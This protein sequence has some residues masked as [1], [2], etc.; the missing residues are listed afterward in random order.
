MTRGESHRTILYAQ[1]G[2]IYAI[3]ALLT[4]IALIPIYIMLVNATRSTEEINLGLSLIPGGNIMHNWEALTRGWGAGLLARGFFNSAFIAISTT[5]LNV[6]FSA[7]TAYG[8]HIYRFKGR[9]V[10]WAAILIIIMLPASLSFI[11]FFQFMANVNLLNNYVPLI[12][13]AIAGA[14]SVLFIRQYM[15]SFTAGAL[16]EAARI[17]G[18]NEFFIFN[19]VVLPL[20]TPA[21]AAQ[22][23]FTFV[24]SW[25]NLLIPFVLISSRDRY[26]LPMLVQMLRGDIFRVEFG[27][28]YLGIAISIVPIV[29]F[30]SF[31]S[32][33]IISGLTLGGVKE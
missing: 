30:Y 31:M 24:G 5:L 26:T 18:A 13:P 20:L 12:I 14:G 10:L 19:R 25:N 4:L 15:A 7:M 3:M 9:N 8:L 2:F 1:R 32:R 23:I 22:S 28:I 29:I 33:L 16:I 17:D 6:Y 11:G 21:L 27:G